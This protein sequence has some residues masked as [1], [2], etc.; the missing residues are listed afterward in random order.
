[1]DG[2]PCSGTVVKTLPMDETMDP[3][4]GNLI[5][6]C[7]VTP[8]SDGIILSYGDRV[9]GYMFYVQNGVPGFCFSSGQRFHALDGDA[10]CLKQPTHL[11]V[12]MDNYNAT[13]KFYVNGALVQTETIYCNLR[14]W[15]QGDDDISL[16]ADPEPWVD[17]YDL[18]KMGGFSGSI[19]SF[20]MQRKRMTDTELTDYARK[21]SAK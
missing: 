17:P 2:L 21:A 3:H 5:Y 20:K 11:L 19:H 8:E 4:F 7:T 18:S 1:P 6:E 10:S 9:S 13:A 15:V 16:G 12:E 14:G